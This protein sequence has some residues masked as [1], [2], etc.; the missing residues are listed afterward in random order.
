MASPQNKVIGEGRD[1]TKT[2]LIDKD[3]INLDS[4]ITCNHK[5]VG[6]VLKD[7]KFQSGVIDLNTRKKKKD[8]CILL[9]FIN[10][11]YGQLHRASFVRVR[12]KPYRQIDTFLPSS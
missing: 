10:F 8:F 11:D 1:A 12:D 2:K 5:Y 9:F 7:D 6:S 4:N 3:D